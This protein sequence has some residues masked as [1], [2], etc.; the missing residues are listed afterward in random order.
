[1]FLD[2]DV[3][4]ETLP[5]GWMVRMIEAKEALEPVMLMVEDD[6]C[7]R[8]SFE[9]TIEAAVTNNLQIIKYIQVFP[10]FIKLLMKGKLSLSR[11]N[12]LPIR[13]S[14]VEANTLATVF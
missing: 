8:K 10:R 5:L 2:G 3:Q 12:G 11:L 7:R 6:E 4:K 13:N 9:I 1:M 14:Y